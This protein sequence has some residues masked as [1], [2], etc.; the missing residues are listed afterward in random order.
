MTIQAARLDRRRALHQ[1]QFIVRPLDR[2]LVIFLGEGDL[3][4]REVTF[5]GDGAQAGAACRLRRYCSY[6]VL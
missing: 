4:F 2:S 1:R 5:S 6:S 3:L